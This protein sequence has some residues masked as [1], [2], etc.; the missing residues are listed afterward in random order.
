MRSAN[1]NCMLTIDEVAR[2]VGV[3]RAR[4]WQC[5]QSALQKIRAA[6]LS[7]P[8]LREELEANGFALAAPAEGD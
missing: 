3:T 5:E 7:D 6:L 8:H 1:P 4:V 2:I